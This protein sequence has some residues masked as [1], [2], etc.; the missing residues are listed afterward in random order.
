MACVIRQ[1]RTSTRR[2]ATYRQRRKLLSEEDAKDDDYANN[3]FYA[4]F[5]ARRYADLREALRDCSPR[6]SRN[7]R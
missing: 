7:A 2:S 1:G 5:Y 3:L 6:V 4:L